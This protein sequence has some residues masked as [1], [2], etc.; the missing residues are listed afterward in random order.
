MYATT[1]D[2]RRVIAVAVLASDGTFMVVSVDDEDFEEVVKRFA[3]FTM[4]FTVYSAGETL[5]YCLDQLP[6]AARSARRATELPRNSLDTLVVRCR[7]QRATVTSV[8]Y[9]C[10]IPPLLGRRPLV[11]QTTSIAVFLAGVRVFVFTRTI[12]LAKGR[13]S[14]ARYWKPTD[15]LFNDLNGKNWSADRCISPSPQ[16]AQ[17]SSPLVIQRFP[18]R[19][20]VGAIDDARNRCS[21]SGRLK[22]LRYSSLPYN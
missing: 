4:L 21:F 17:S 1:R 15:N 16:I 20:G 10:L 2:A 12:L 22:Y 9:S 5:A 7:C 19:H 11:T 8:K 18:V 3:V 6:Q 14:M 13:Y